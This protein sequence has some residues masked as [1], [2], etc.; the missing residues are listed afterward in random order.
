MGVLTE[1]ALR[2]K[3]KN[4]R[5]E[6]FVVEKGVII[7]PSARQ[8]LQDKNIK[9]VIGDEKKSVEEKTTVSSN[10]NDKRIYPTFKAIQGGYFDKKPEF[11][12]SL[13]GNELVFK[14]HPIIELRG[15]FDSLQAKTLSVQIL[16]DK[17]GEKKIVKDLQDIL[18]YE[19]K[20][21]IAEIMKEDLEEVKL[22]GHTFAEIR[23]MSHNPKKF[24]GI[25]HI[26]YPEYK[27]G[28][29]FAAINEVRSNI[30]ECEVIAMKAFKS[31][32]GQIEREDILRALNRL[33]S[34]VYVVMCKLLSGQYKK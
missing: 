24:F 30:R 7:T 26:W 4:S 21:M 10:D 13:Y 8:Y 32:Y 9:L 29:L 31:Q 6:E 14:D 23:S 22:I 5:P 25:E 16:A 2:A 19:R 20:I 18:D 12:T 11:M 17:V 27:Y 33:S 1:H 15:K 28:E 34:C 3:L